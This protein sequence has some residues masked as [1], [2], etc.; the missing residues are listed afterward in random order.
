MNSQ[1]IRPSRL[2]YAV[3]GGLLAGALT[4][5]VLAIIGLVSLSRQVEQF[6]RVTVPGQAEVVFTESGR[7]LIYLEGPGI[8][9]RSSTGDVPV[10]LQPTNG[11][12]P[13]EIHQFQGG[14]RTYHLAGHEGVTAGFLH[15]DQPGSYQLS[16]GEATRPGI[17]HVAVGRDIVGGIFAPVVLLIAGVILGLAALAVGLVTAVRRYY[18]RR[19]SARSPELTAS[20]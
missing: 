15:I 8:S 12:P 11:G 4:C 19:S 1:A 14:Y 3:A 18:A 6:Q 20:R 10:A 13:I 16:A 2:W 17:T 9:T 5:L 7:Y